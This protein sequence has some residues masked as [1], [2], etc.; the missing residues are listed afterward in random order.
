[1]RIDDN[2]ALITDQIR[3]TATWN[4]SKSV[5]GIIG[6]KG[7]TF[8][9]DTRTGA[10]ATVRTSGEIG[11]SIDYTV[12]AGTVTP[13]LSYTAKA[14]I[15]D[16][17]ALA[18][19][20]RFNLTGNSGLSSGTFNVQ[21]PTAE[22]SV[23]AILNIS[24][25]ASG[26]ACFVFL[27]CASGSDDFSIDET[28]ELFS[29]DLSKARFL[30]GIL[31]SFAKL[32]VPV[33]DL[34]AT[35]VQSISSGRT[36]L[37]LPGGKTVPSIP[38]E[39]PTRTIAEANLTIPKVSESDTTISG[40]A[41]KNTGRSDFL[42]LSV[43]LDGL[44]GLPLSGDGSIKLPG[45]IPDINVGYDLLDIDLGPVLGF[46]QSYS[47][48]S[49]LMVDFIFDQP[50]DIFG[51]DVMSYSGAWDSLPDMSVSS[52][53]EFAP[54]FWL[55]TSIRSKAFLD[56]NIGLKAEV[57]S[58]SVLGIDIG[59]LY[60]KTFST[61]S[62]DIPIFDRDF[63]FL[64]FNSIF[65]TPFVVTPMPAPYVAVAA[66]PLPAPALLL[67]GGIAG[68]TGLGWRRRRP[69]LSPVDTPPHRA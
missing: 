25:G 59:P 27:G 66:V 46:N 2:P 43:D 24:A 37:E 33:G 29:A 15:P 45:A 13:E 4:K 55:Q 69:D 28:V 60:E 61:K 11:Y 16:P 58:A 19:G 18:N 68:M 30:G 52:V 7:A 36:Q 3:Q 21:A 22:L 39:P 44:S 35:L 64:G 20:Q 1:M 12:S 9:P 48:T 53:T 23:D 5:G 57:L 14:F 62:F 42:D 8:R 6:R 50:V 67:L 10:E 49:D 31:P 32:E 63:A 17:G 51:V 65:E 26:K 54:K 34:N 56:L 41:I 40:N 47:L 38:V